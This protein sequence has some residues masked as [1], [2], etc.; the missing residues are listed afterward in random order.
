VTADVAEL[1]PIAITTSSWRGLAGLGAAVSGLAA[2]LGA[3]LA[4]ASVFLD[5][6][7]T[8]SDFAPFG[9]WQVYVIEGVFVLVLLTVG[10]ASG[11]ITVRLS[12]RLRGRSPHTRAVVLA[13]LLPGLFVGSLVGMPMRGTVSWASDH[14]AAADAARV[15]LSRLQHDYRLAPPL[16]VSMRP[17]AAPDLVS[18]MLAPADLGKG[19]YAVSRPNATVSPIS[20][21]ASTRGATTAVHTSLTQEHWTGTSWALDRFLVQA[22]LVFPGR[23]AAVGYVRSVWAEPDVTSTLGAAVERRVGGVIVWERMPTGR[24]TPAH[25]AAAFVVGGT[26]FTVIL[27]VSRL[28]KGATSAEFTRVVAAAVERAS[29][30]S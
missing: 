8:Y 15:E 18:R 16:I 22:Q 11:A 27:D 4:L 14:T 10:L 6:S 13:A 25:A 20:P 29:P 2:S 3:G 5:R 19:W 26:L 21:E 17:A 12:R 7:D 30:R 9:G 24:A 28:G 23:D 1:A